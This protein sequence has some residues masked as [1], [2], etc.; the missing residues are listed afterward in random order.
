M[1]TFLFQDAESVSLNYHNSGSVLVLASDEAGVRALVDE[2]NQPD[3][4]TPAVVLSEDD[5]SRV[6]VFELDSSHRA[7]APQL[8]IFPDSGCC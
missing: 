2:Y 6:R 7:D 4:S 1:K 5:W 8:F 3:R